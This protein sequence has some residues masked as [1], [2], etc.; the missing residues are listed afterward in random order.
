MEAVEVSLGAWIGGLLAVPLISLLDLGHRLWDLPFVPYNVWNWQTHVVPGNVLS[1]AVN[2][3]GFQLSR[4]LNMPN[5]GLGK[6]F[7]QAAALLLAVGTSAALGAVVA[8]G[9]RQRGRGA[10]LVGVGVGLLRFA[11]VVA[12]E[13]SLGLGSPAVPSLL[14]L[15]M[16]YLGWGVLVGVLLDGRLL[17]SLDSDTYPE[18]RRGFVSLVGAALGGALAIWGIGRFAGT[19]VSSSGAGEPL[20]ETSPAPT[21][22]AQVDVG[23]MAVAQEENVPVGEDGR[24]IPVPGTRPEVTPKGQFYRVDIATTPVEIAGESWTLTLDGLFEKTSALTLEDLRG[25][26]VH[27]QPITLCCVSNPTAGSAISTAYWTGLRLKDLLEDLGLKPEANYLFLESADGF[28]ETVTMA[29]MMDPQT[30]LVYGMNDRTLPSKHGYPLRIYIPNRYGMKQP[31]WIMK[32]TAT[33][34]DQGGYWTDRGWSKEARPHIT[35]VIDVV[36]KDA[37]HDGLVP[38]GGV[39]WAG[40]RGIQQVELKIDAEPWREVTLRTPPLGPLTWVQW[41]YE[42]PASPGRHTLTVRAT[43]GDGELQ[44][45][46]KTPVRPDGPTGYHV[47][48]V[49]I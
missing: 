18:R 32:M 16:L 49:T 26:P 46:K 47:Q 24:I 20:T 39:A 3:L 1:L 31:K 23:A 14:W 30:L 5:V 2:G 17:A 37:M 12:I 41:R 21:T 9:L 28:Y 45:A 19:G 43:D 22:S 48:R 8:W 25:Y 29:D 33:E 42:W 15:T 35:S 40:D 27:T 36:A 11:A 13:L 7:E 10:W 4:L 34:E 44:I 38:V 6:R